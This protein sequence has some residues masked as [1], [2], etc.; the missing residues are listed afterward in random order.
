MMSASSGGVESMYFLLTLNPDVTLKDSRGR[1]ALHRAV[2]K[3]P[4]L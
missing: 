1:A 3:F 2:S 4:S